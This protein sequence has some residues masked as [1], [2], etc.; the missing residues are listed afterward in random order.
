MYDERAYYLYQY[1]TE[2]DDWVYDDEGNLVPIEGRE[3]LD[4]NSPEAIAYAV[5]QGIEP[6]DLSYM[7]EGTRG[8]ED[9]YDAIDMVFYPSEIGRQFSTQY[10][11]GETIKRLAVMKDFGD[12]NKYILD[13]WENVKTNSL[14]LWAIIL[15]IVEGVVALAIVLYLFIKKRV[16]KT[17]RIK[18]RKALAK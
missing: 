1:N 15:L 5:S 4:W 13:M 10:P 8:G 2:K 11:D 16:N 18:R 9:D 12:N 7:F 14:P 6:V 3:A 17:L